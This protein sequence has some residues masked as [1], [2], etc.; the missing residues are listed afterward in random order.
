MKLL[1]WSGSPLA[2]PSRL[3][4]RPVSLHGLSLLPL[5]ALLAEPLL[6]PQSL[7]QCC[8]LGTLSY[9]EKGVIFKGWSW[10]VSHFYCIPWHGSGSLSPRWRLLRG[11]CRVP[12]RLCAHPPAGWSQ[13]GRRSRSVAV[14]FLPGSNDLSPPGHWTQCPE[15]KG[16]TAFCFYSLALDFSSWGCDPRYVGLEWILFL[17]KHVNRTTPSEAHMDQRD[18]ETIRFSMLFLLSVR[19][20]TGGVFKILCSPFK[21]SMMVYIRFTSRMASWMHWNPQ[22]TTRMRKDIYN[23]KHSTCY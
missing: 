13:R 16:S 18:Y 1:Q 5:R 22:S 8:P 14:R 12:P 6:P 2:F 3:P 20:E 9:S 10:S 4:S 21:Y 15:E 11:G 23:R 7:S 17:W 19:T